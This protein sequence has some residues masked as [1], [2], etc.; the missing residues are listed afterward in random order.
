[1]FV[2]CAGFRFVLIT[3]TMYEREC[4]KWLIHDIILK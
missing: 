2:C 1:M 3:P 4:V